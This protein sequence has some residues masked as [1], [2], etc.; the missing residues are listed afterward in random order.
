MRKFT[1]MGLKKWG[2]QKHPKWRIKIISNGKGVRIQFNE[3]TNFLVNVADVKRALKG[4]PV[5]MVVKRKQNMVEV[6]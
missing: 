4:H 2:R 1:I 6:L 3:S 5:Y